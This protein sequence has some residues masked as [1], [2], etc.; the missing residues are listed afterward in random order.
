MRPLSGFGA[1][2][3]VRHGI[4]QPAPSASQ[5]ISLRVGVRR[6]RLTRSCPAPTPPAR[7]SAG[8][9]PTGRTCLQA[10]RTRGDATR[11]CRDRPWRIPRAE[12][13][14]PPSPPPSPRRAHR[15]HSSGYVGPTRTGGIPNALQWNRLLRG[16]PRTPATPIGTFRQQWLGS[17]RRR[18]RTVAKHLLTPTSVESP[19]HD[20]TAT[21]PVGEGSPCF[22]AAA[23]RAG[24]RRECARTIQ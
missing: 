1:P 10:G 13:P 11:A 19:R 23:G 17:R 20:T 9:R 22:F 4:R 15:S 5:R 18:D 3:T 16:S 6:H 12:P 8:C 7:P 21:E 14:E 2:L 24:R